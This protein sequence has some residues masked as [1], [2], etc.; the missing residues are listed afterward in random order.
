MKFETA[1]GRGEHGDFAAR[2]LILF[3]G[4]LRVRRQGLI[5]EGIA[6]VQDRFATI[7]VVSSR[8]SCHVPAGGQCA[9]THSYRICDQN[10]A[11][12]CRGITYFVHA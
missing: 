6:K 9:K 11:G 5:H 3:V 8:R 4:A 7:C 10:N 2:V 1:F 12:L